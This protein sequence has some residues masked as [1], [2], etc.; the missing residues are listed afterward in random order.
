[1]ELLLRINMAKKESNNEVPIFVDKLLEQA[2]SRG[3]SDVYLL[4]QRECMKMRMR[5]DGIQEDVDAVDGTFGSQ[6]AARVKVLAKLLTYRTR[7]PQ[8]GSFQFGGAEFRVAV[9]PTIHGE[10]ITIRVMNGR[11]APRTLDQLGFN[12]QITATLRS[13][14]LPSGLIILTGP[15]GCGKTTTVYAM[16]RELLNNDQDPSSIITVE[17]PVECEL[18]GISQCELKRSEDDENDFVFWETALKSALRQDVKTLVIGEMRDQSVVRIALEAA[19]TGHRV[20]STYHAG[21]I[22]S[23]YARI[24]HQGF[25]PFLVAAAVS[26]IVSQRLFHTRDHGIVPIAACLQPS[27][28]WRDFIMTRPGLDQ[29]R[30][31]IKS[32][33]NADLEQQAIQ[34]ARQGLISEE[35]VKL[36]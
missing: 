9:M 8:D 25:E 23:V 14:L 15:T 12:P 18:P 35:Q 6:C 32:D 31:K 21:D 22:A 11:A 4:P 3:A 33:P 5:I 24:M 16:L 10:R 28:S 34:A 20:I 13:M 1:M 26:G 36:L 2:I 27:D 7:I 17:D 19:L 29:L 30:K